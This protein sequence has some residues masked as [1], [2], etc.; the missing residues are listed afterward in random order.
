[1]S[2]ADAST[3]CG[4]RTSDG[5]KEKSVW[6]HVHSVYAW[7]RYKLQGGISDF[8]QSTNEAFATGFEAL[9]TAGGRT[10]SDD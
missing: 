1:M 7:G 9:Q 4:L 6:R 3:K 10:A 8:G 5:K 2:R